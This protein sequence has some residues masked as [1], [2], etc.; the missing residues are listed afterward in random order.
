MTT[1]RIPRLLAA[2]CAALLLA[3]CG[4]P[5]DESARTA[6]KT[7][8]AASRHE[9]AASESPRYADAN[10]DG[11]VTRDEAKVYAALEDNFDRFDMDRNGELDRGEFA[12]LEME[13]VDRPPLTIEPDS[14]S[15]RPRGE[16]AR[17][18][19]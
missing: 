1:N 2:S 17:P 6:G 4:E 11:R 13:A 15:Q 16:F 10:R 5:G 9:A 7:T 19:D 14:S 18:S 12:R 8:D 3:G